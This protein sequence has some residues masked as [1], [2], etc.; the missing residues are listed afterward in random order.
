MEIQR[1]GSVVWLG[2]HEVQ[3]ALRVEIVRADLERGDGD[4]REVG[5]GVPYC[6][7]TGGGAED[8]HFD[9]RVC[10]Q[11]SCF[12]ALAAGVADECVVVQYERGEW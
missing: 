12:A 5:V 10:G 6:S 7:E 11:V 1:E 9:G 4:V 2:G 3:H 8:F